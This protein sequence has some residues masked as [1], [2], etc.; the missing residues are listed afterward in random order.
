MNSSFLVYKTSFAVK[1]S[2]AEHLPLLLWTLFN[3]T[4]SHQKGLLCDSG[5]VTQYVAEVLQS[6]FK[7]YLVVGK[8]MCNNIIAF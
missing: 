5:I 2:S 6:N 4:E 7:Y 1:V 3:V 8:M